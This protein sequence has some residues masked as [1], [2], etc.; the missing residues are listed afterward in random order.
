M[1]PSSEAKFR[2]LIVDSFLAA[3]AAAD[4]LKI[5]AG[6]LPA[7]DEIRSFRKTIVVGAG[8]AAASMAM[9]V[10]NYWPNDTLLSGLVVT[11][12]G[13]GLPCKHIEVIQ[14]GHPVPD[15]AGEKAAQSIFD[16]VAGASPDD[17]VIMLISGGG[18]SLLSLPVPDVPMGDL[19]SLTQKLLA[20]GAPIQDMNVVRKHLSLIQGGR[21]AQVCK[22]KMLTL[23]ISDVVGDDLSAIASG[24]TVP[25]PSTYADAIAILKKYKVQPPQSISDRLNRG[26]SGLETETPKPGDACFVK[27]QAH[28]IAT[29][30]ASLN[31]GAQVFESA[32]VKAI[33]LGD[34]IEGEASVVGRQFSE[35]LSEFAMSKAPNQPI[36]I[37]SG[38]ECTVTLKPQ[39]SSEAKA[40]GGR[41]SEFLLGFL[42]GLESVQ[43]N[44]QVFGLAADTDGID[45]S[46]D[47]AGALFTA[48]SLGRAALLNLQA[49]EFLQRNDAYGYFQALGDLVSTGPTLTNVNDYR[50]ILLV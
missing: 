41:C 45:G 50:V 16:L 38:G 22:A 30:I 8:K 1:Q 24:P 21:L 36:A 42:T 32:G 5:V 25:D 19:R 2:Q 12:Y 39:A 43:F 4:P 6:F 28:L 31:A 47:N 34:N 23:V 27:C 18:S 9:A 7:H 11:R 44:G 13:H 40:R 14:A 10:E 33:C 35:R 29:A 3:V 20:S 48:G 15:E 17:L 26:Q 37:I 46:Q 49:N